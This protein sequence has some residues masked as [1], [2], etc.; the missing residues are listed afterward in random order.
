M[1]RSR[2]A[3]RGDL[4]ELLR[5]VSDGRRD[6]GRDHPSAAVLA[7]AAAA[8]VAGMTGYRAIADWI[9]DVPAQI[10]QDLYRRAGAVAVGP[11]GL[12][13]IWRVL[14]GAEAGT[15]ENAAGAWLSALRSGQSR[16]VDAFERGS[17]VGEVAAGGP[18][19]GS[20]R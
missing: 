18:R 13:T 10:L 2:S 12:T 15:L 14:S 19:G 1:F 9:A 8:T 17:L 5:A 7:L 11:P 16:E 3:G 4:L 20:G 6:Q